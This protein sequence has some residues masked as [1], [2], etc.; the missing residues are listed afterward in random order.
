MAQFIAVKSRVKG[1]KRKGTEI[2]NGQDG[3][4]YLDE[5]KKYVTSNFGG[6]AKTV[7]YDKAK[8]VCY[9]VIY[10][11]M[12]K[13]T[14][15]KVEEYRDK[16]RHLKHQIELYEQM[17]QNNNNDLELLEELQKLQYE[18]LTADKPVF[19]VAA[20]KTMQQQFK[21]DLLSRHPSWKILL[22]ETGGKVINL[23]LEKKIEQQELNKKDNDWIDYDVVIT[24]MSIVT[25][26]NLSISNFMITGVYPSNQANREQ[27]I[28][29]IDRL[30][31]SENEV[32][33]EIYHAGILSFTNMKY[34][35]A[36]ALENS[37]VN[38]F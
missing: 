7:N 15:E 37:L 16:E 34:Q 1:N 14:E 32:F 31:Q 2:E 36:R 33:V 26:Y 29:R 12:L 35:N 13:R 19:L 23:T 6:T 3:K 17:Q 22:I 20:D 25:G 8:E 21:T 5:Y 9:K 24:T 18:R 38:P 28:G 4:N 11:Q 30:G 10:G 27:L